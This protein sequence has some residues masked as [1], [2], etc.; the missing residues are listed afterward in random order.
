MAR[1]QLDGYARCW[2]CGKQFRTLKAMD[3]HTPECKQLPNYM[4]RPKKASRGKATI[5]RP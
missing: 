4:Q 5:L 1:E 2:W 3:R